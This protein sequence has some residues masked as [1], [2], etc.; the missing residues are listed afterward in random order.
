M[1]KYCIVNGDDFGASHGI[2]QGIIEAHQ[3]GVLTSTSLMVNMAGTEE[4]VQMSVKSPNLSIGL[5][6]VLTNENWEPLINFD[7]KNEC[8]VELEHQWNSFCSLTG[9]IP[10]HLDAHH[11]IYRDARLT[12]LFADWARLKNVPLREHSRVRYFSEFYGQ[13]DGETHLEQI[14]EDNLCL[15]LR[16]KIGEGFT[17]LSCHPGYVDKDY[18]TAYSIEREAELQTLCSPLIKK[19]FAEL[20]IELINYI[21]YNK[22]VS[23]GNKDNIT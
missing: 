5:H 6:V 19:T 7:S 1:K 3:E 10:T 4:A 13:W 17:E 18:S 22:I 16:T 9:K 14:S 20:E 21:D 8:R 11:N 12:S 2:N 23:E 15:M